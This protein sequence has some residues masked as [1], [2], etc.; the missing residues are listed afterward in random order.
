M[1]A[2]FLVATERKH[3]ILA[4]SAAPRWH[5]CR[6]SVAL[7]EALRGEGC[8]EGS[9]AFADEGTD[10][11]TLAARCVEDGKTAKEYTGQSLPLGTVVT[12]GMARHVQRYLDSLSEYFANALAGYSWGAELRVTAQLTPSLR[13]SGTSDLVLLT[14]IDSELQVHDLKFGTGVKVEALENEQLLLYGMGALDMLPKKEREQIE[15][16]RLV[17][18]QPRL[19]HL[20]EWTL[21]VQSSYFSGLDHWRQSLRVS[22]EIAK[23]LIGEPLNTIRPHLVTGPKQCRFCPA[24]T[25]CPA[26]IE[27]AMSLTGFDPGKLTTLEVSDPL[28]VHI[29][30]HLPALRTFINRVEAETMK[31]AKET[32]LPGYKLVEGRKG[33]RYWIDPEKAMQELVLSGLPASEIA[34]PTLLSPAKIE[35][36]FS[37]VEAQEKLL[38]S[39]VDQK[40]GEL[41][42]A[43]A[44]DKRPAATIE[45]LEFDT[46][47][48]ET[49]NLFGDVT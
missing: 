38:V 36:G 6:G 4:P 37:L 22:A 11:H 43:P 20:S 19:Y 7:V 21:P 15:Q 35:D 13:I 49:M 41:T 44:T 26:M 42:L 14:Y 25:R 23:E 29:Y 32:G 47:V 3:D 1:T 40:Q 8:G 48:G 45:P 12:P 28:L 33:N 17:I 5:R 18:H 30:E 39:L 24:I 9:S 34:P 27:E 10:A 2:V 16:L 31:R 46:P